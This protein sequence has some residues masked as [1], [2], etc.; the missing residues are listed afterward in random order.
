MTTFIHWAAKIVNI[1]AILALLFV[2]ATQARSHEYWLIMLFLVPPVLSVWALLA[3][4][5]PA[6]RKL[7]KDV[8]MARLRKELEELNS[9]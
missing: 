6:E 4:M 9:K 7:S 8:R 3:G 1:I 2:F 5:S